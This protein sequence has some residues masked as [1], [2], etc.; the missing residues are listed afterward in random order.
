MALLA[1]WLLLATALAAPASR[2]ARK[3]PTPAAAA[4]PQA[5]TATD[6]ELLLL[7]EGFIPGELAG[8]ERDTGGLAKL[9]TYRV[10]LA[11]DVEGAA[12]TGTATI[13]YP[14]GATPLPE[15]PLRVLV[16]APYLVEQMGGPPLNVLEVSCPEGC[17][18]RPSGDPTLLR[19]GFASPKAAWSVA[20]ATIRFRVAI[21][22]LPEPPRGDAALFDQMNLMTSNGGKPSDHGALGVASGVWSLIHAVPMVAA[23]SGSSFDVTAPSGIGDP[24][25]ADPSNLLLTLDTPDGF[26]VVGPGSALGATPQKDGTSRHALAASAIR[27]VPLYASR[28]WA[29]SEQ[30]A[31]GT[32]VVAW[33]LKADEKQSRKVLDTAARALLTFNKRFGTYPWRELDVVEQV[34]TEGVGGLES[35]TVVGLSTSVYLQQSSFGMLGGLLGNGG[36][37]QLGKRTANLDEMDKGLEFVVAHVVAHQWWSVMVGNDPRAHPAVDE[38]LT[39]YA[40]V[41]YVEGRRGKAMGQQAQDNNLALQFQLMRLQGT[42]DAAADQSAESFASPLQYN[43]VL[44]GKAPLY[45]REVRKLLGDAAFDRALQ[46]HVASYRFHMATPGAFGESCTR[47]APAKAKQLGDLERR[48]LHELHGDDDLGPLDF[49]KLLESATGTR[50]SAEEKALMNGLLPG[51]MQMLMQNGGKGLPGLLGGQMDDDEDAQPG[52]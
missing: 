26:E 30:K 41:L 14:V 13:R 40:S 25:L 36:R 31:G 17:E 5:A 33:T 23:R 12:L 2:P 21:P 19:I 52:P 4:D 45:Y 20:E 44:Y 27:D 8:V 29:R 18:Q 9:P 3:A 28:N 15:L 49:G 51:V 35:S 39:Q 1:P 24:G 22:K 11:L 6:A 16:N 32:T 50:M 47:V 7:R 38:A 43:G 42:A 34:V 37:P 10:Q 46:R 48:W